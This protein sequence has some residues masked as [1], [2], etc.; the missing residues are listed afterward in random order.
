M[1]VLIRAKRVEE[2]IRK[3]A[4]A[5]GETLTGL[6]ERAVDHLEATEPAR[7]GRGR[8]DREGLA[9][10]LAEIRALPVV[11]PRSPDEIIG[12][13]EFGLPH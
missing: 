7:K 2:K 3:L 12:Y 8:V 1:A 5:R 11:D 6:V 10:L 13:D 9:R 4:R